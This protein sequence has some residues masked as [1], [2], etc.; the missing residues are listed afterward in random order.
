[1]EE[2]GVLGE[3]GGGKKIARGEEE[4]R[5]GDFSSQVSGA[6]WLELCSIMRGKINSRQLHT[7]QKRFPNQFPPFSSFLRQDKNLKAPQ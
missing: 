2:V 5:G 3:G 1:M 6:G 7:M 4:E